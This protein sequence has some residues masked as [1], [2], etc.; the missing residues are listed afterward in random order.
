[1]SVIFT[2]KNYDFIGEND[3]S[4]Q[5]NF[6]HHSCLDIEYIYIIEYIIE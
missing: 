2:R 3:K 5:R 4:L 6:M 1:M